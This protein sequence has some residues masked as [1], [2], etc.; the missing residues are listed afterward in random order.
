MSENQTMPYEQA[1][2]AYIVGK[3]AINAFLP[4][5]L[6]LGNVATLQDVTDTVAEAL[7][8][9]LAMSGWDMSLSQ[10]IDYGQKGELAARRAAEQEQAS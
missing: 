6:L 5:S 8:E 10:L 2:A 9:G 7:T 1:I 4:A 3:L